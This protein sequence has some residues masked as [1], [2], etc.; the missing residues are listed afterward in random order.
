[1]GWKFILTVKKK[2]MIRGYRKFRCTNCKHHFKG[3]DIEYACT[4][5]STPLRCPQC[6]SIKTMPAGIIF[7]RSAYE[8]IWEEMER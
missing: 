8:K 3:M 7:G 4:V 6:G 1:M 2:D 5:Y